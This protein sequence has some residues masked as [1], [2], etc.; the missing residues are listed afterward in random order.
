[1]TE[2]TCYI[3]NGY[4]FAEIDGLGRVLID[5]TSPVNISDKPFVAI[6]D[7][8]FHFTKSFMGRSA[9]TISKLIGTEIDALI[10]S[11]I[12]SQFDVF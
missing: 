12:L 10:G 2:Y 7:R 11:N 1:M 5:S 8:K 3:T 4:L 6:M 9:S